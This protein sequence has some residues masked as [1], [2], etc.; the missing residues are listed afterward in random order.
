MADAGYSRGTPPPRPSL[1]R[2]STAPQSVKGSTDLPA[3]PSLP[4]IDLTHSTLSPETDSDFTH[5]PNIPFAHP[6][7]TSR[8]PGTGDQL[9][10]SSRQSVSPTSSLRKS[11]SVDSFVSAR[12]SPPMSNSP[13]YTRSSPSGP[14]QDDFRPISQFTPSPYTPSPD[15]PHVSH[16]E[17]DPRYPLSGRS[18]GA[19]VSTMAEDHESHPGASED[20]DIISSDRSRRISTKGKEKPRPIIS[21]GDL[22]LPPKLSSVASPAVAGDPSLRDNTPRVSTPSTASTPKWSAQFAPSTSQAGRSRSGSVGMAGSTS[23]LRSLSPNVNSGVRDSQFRLG[24]S[25]LANETEDSSSFMGAQPH[26]M[27]TAPLSF[28]SARLIPVP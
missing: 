24:C 16:R 21:S 17:R 4:P 27:F 6:I 3:I 20:E 15:H 8:T 25:A 18:R 13:H 11:F 1:R 9:A 19:S 22:N 23:R 5:R 12:A 7:Q 28:V 2:I 26:N 10:P 14:Y